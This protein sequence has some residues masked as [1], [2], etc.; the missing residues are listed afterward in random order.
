MVA[1]AQPKNNPIAGEPDN[2]ATTQAHR[3]SKSKIRRFIS[4]L[5]GF[6]KPNPVI[7]RLGLRPFAGRLIG[8]FYLQP[9]LV[10]L[11]VLIHVEHVVF[12]Y[13]IDVGWQLSNGSN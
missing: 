8:W 9:F 3:H 7:T 4:S 6:L 12:L 2:S 13:A 10:G 11:L 5:L 1:T